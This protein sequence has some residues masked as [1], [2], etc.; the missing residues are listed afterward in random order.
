ME[1]VVG[2]RNLEERGV[3]EEMGFV[4]LKEVKR[5]LEPEVVMMLVAVAWLVVV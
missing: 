2:V 3:E 1:V 4:G 5:V